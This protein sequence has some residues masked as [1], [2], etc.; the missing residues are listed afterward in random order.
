MKHF[1]IYRSVGHKYIVTVEIYRQFKKI[2]LL[3]LFG[4][5]QTEVG[6]CVVI[7]SETNGSVNLCCYLERNKRKCDCVLLFGAKQTEV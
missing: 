3:F 5:K 7:W 4:A 2:S 1:F 6:M